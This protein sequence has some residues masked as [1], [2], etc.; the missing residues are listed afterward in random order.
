MDQEIAQSQGN[1]EMIMVVVEEITMM[2]V[3]ATKDNEEMIMEEV[4]EVGIKTRMTTTEE[5]VG[6]KLQIIKQMEETNGVLKETNL[7]LKVAGEK[8]NRYNQKPL[9]DGVKTRRNQVVVVEEMTGETKILRILMIKTEEAA[10]AE[11]P[12]VYKIEIKFTVSFKIKFV[13]YISSLKYSYF[14]F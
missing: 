8:R 2:T 10:G 11:Y 14:S 7:K 5:T 13:K 6:V 3:E 12:N 4:M 9:E 1:L